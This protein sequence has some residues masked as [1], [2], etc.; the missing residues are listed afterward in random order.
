[1]PLKELEFSFPSERHALAAFQAISPELENPFEKRS[2]VVMQTNKNVVL[3]K[4][5]ADDEQAMKA[6]LYTYKRFFGLC[7]KLMF[8]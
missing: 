5:N 3:L 8:I 1:M 4:I 7:E 2:K 6:S